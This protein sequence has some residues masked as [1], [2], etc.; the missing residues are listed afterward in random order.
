[1]N[2]LPNQITLARL[3]ILFIVCW[4][5]FSERHQTATFAVILF[6]LGCFTDWLDGFVARMW[7]MSSPFGAYL[8]AVVDKIFVIGM[9]MTMIVKG[10]MPNW[11]VFLMLL[12]ISREF[13]ITALRSV[14]ATKHV[15]IAAETGGKWKTIAQM[16]S[17][18]I[19]LAWNCFAKDHPHAFSETGLK[20]LHAIGISLFCIAAFLTL[21]S[22]VKYLCKYRAVIRD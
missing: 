4:L 1:M 9:F 2:N 13:L 5:L 7:N 14:A 18:I 12:I 17:Q 20:H 6:F 21:T 22:G 19:L 3:P 15:V 8:D 16:A 11:T 10:I